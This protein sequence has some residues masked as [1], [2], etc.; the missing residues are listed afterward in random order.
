MKSTGIIRR[1]DDLGRIVIPKEIRRTI[2]V[3]EDDPM[4]IF[5]NAEGEI[6]LKKYSPIDQ[7]SDFAQEYCDSLYEFTGHI[8]LIGDR[9]N[10][11]AVSGVSKS[12]Y[13]DQSLPED[14][15]NLIEK[16]RI[17]STDNR[18]VAP[19]IAEGDPVGVII[20]LVKDEG[21]T[22]CDF[23]VKI[24]QIAASFL[25]KQVGD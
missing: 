16:H 18:V 21:K 4:E 6:I 11:I 22:M 1:I 9:D 25:A 24:A 3:R 23:E 17:S 12:I 2:R 15:Q 20:L 5:I 10:W 8:I 14:I 13:I 7:L 19:I